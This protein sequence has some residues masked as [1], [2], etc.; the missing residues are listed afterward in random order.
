MKKLLGMIAV[1]LAIATSAFTV[2]HKEA[3][4]GSD[5]FNYKM[6]GKTGQDLAAN[7]TNPANYD[8]VPS[9]NCPIAGTHRCGVFNATDDGTG[10]P[11]FSQ[12]FTIQSRN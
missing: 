11:D 2:N 7:L 9:L 3:K 10:H 6:Y 5:S 8:L 4:V 12:S 1:V